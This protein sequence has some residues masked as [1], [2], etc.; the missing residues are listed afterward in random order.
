MA[1]S[2]HVTVLIAGS[3]CAGHTAAIYAARADL[4]PL[5]L[6]GNEPG[7]QLSLTSDVENYPGFPEGIGGFDLTESMKKQA[8][9]FGARYEYGRIQKLERGGPPFTIHL[10]GSGTLTC[11]AL[12]LATG[13]RARML[14]VP[15][16]KELFGRGVSSCATCDG[17]FFRDQV[18][19]VVGGG[20]SAMEEALFLTRFARK[21]LV[22]HRRDS[23]RASKIMQDRA[24][25]H[26]KIE[27]HWNTQVAAVNGDKEQGTVQSVDVLVHPQGNPAQRLAHAGGDAARAGVERK[28]LPCDGVFLGVGH[29]PNTDFIEPGTIDLD[30]EGY[31]LTV[32]GHRVTDDVKTRIEGIFAC[33]DVVDK[34]YRQAVTA[35]GM[36]CRAAMEA[37]EYLARKSRVQAGVG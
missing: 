14:E 1:D 5:V 19:V 10:E 36:G 28:V 26:E 15:G 6:E 25:V 20:D 4:E 33:G 16:E 24:L 7:G 30:E 13:A 29:I 11:D 8:E 9:R 27:F 18:V 23:L 3:G 37:E 32:R 31:I 21:V 12:I 22:L 17:A 35:A 34:R 2:R